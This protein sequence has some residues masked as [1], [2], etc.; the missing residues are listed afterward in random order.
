MDDSSIYLLILIVVGIILVAPIVAL[1]RASRASKRATALEAELQAGLKT[2]REL[3]G[4]IYA[5]E[6][7]NKS[8]PG[9]TAAPTRIAPPGQT[10]PAPQSVPEPIKAV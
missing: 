6:Q 10:V 9:E 3:T 7:A 2:L 5:L 8:Q 1:V 4:R